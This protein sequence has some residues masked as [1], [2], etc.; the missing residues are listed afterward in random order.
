MPEVKFTKEQLK[1]AKSL[2][3]RCDSSAQAKRALKEQGVI[4]SAS[5]LRDIKARMIEP[6]ERKARVF[7]CKLTSREISSL[8]KLLMKPNPPTFEELG[9]KFG[10]SKSSIS[11]YKKRLGLKRKK[12]TNCHHLTDKNK[13]KRL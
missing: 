1:L 13:E 2:L 3:V 6:K 5:Y 4:M 7:P 8:K 10:V 12:R 11:R 9:N